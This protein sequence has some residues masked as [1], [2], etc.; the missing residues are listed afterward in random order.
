MA[1]RSSHYAGAMD[2]NAFHLVVAAVLTVVCVII[3]ALIWKR[4]QV[5]TVFWWIGLSMVP[6]AVYLLGL[7][8]SVVGAY[9]TL[10]LW[11]GTLTLTPVVWVGVVL[12]GLAAFLMFGSRLIPSESRKDRRAAAKA[13]AKGAQQAP[14]ASPRPGISPRPAQTPGATAPQQPSPGARKAGAG[15]DEEFD[16]IAELLRKRGIN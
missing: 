2:P 1:L 11:W 3:T 4:A 15:G 8:P 12:A 10:R 9:D 16:E 5:K 6:M 13:S 14:A 7:A